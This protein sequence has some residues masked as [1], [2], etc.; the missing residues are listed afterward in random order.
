MTTTSL[1]PVDALVVMQRMFDEGFATGDGAIVDEL[2]SPDLV[3]H[4][5]GL[6]G[7]RG[8]GDRS[9]SRT[10]CGTCTA[11]SPTSRSP[12]RTPW[13]PGDTIWVRVRGR[14][15]G[16]RPVLRAAQRPAGGL[17]RDRH[18]PRRRRPHRR[19][20]GRARPLRR[21]RPD[22]ACS[23]GWRETVRGK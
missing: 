9:T 21:A 3:E 18:R 7:A 1:D 15:H 19:A 5:F 12:S 17:H 6:A 2:C 16:D 20:L 8:R 4:Q 23:T 10:P 14:G 11:P 22:R 13:S